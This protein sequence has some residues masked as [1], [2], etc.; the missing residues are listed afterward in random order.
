MENPFKKKS[1]EITEHFFR[2]EYGRILPVITKYLGTENIITAEDIVQETLL[3]AVKYWQHHGIPQNPQAWLYTTAKNLTFNT[4]K[5]EKFQH[6]YQK[7]L[8]QD[9]ATI[10]QLIFTDQIITDEQLRMMFNCCHPAITE[11][12]QITLILKVL[13]GFSISEIANAFFTSK[14]TINKRLVRGRKKLREIGFSLQN[15]ENTHH[16]LPIVLKTIYLIFNEGYYPSHKNKVI[17]YDLC[18]EAIRLL[19]IIIN[20]HVIQQKDGA[21]ALLALMYLNASRFEARVS[22]DNEI[23][24]LENQNRV[25][26]DQTLINRGIYCLNHAIAGGHI[27]KYLILANISAQ[28]CIAPDFQSTNWTE[29][30]K[31][32]DY[33]LLL[34]DTPINHLN[35]CVALSK[36][37]GNQTAI[38]EL[39]NIAG[40]STLNDYYLYHTTL[41]ELYTLTNDKAI[42]ISHY[43]QAI[44]LVQNPRDKSFIEKKIARLVPIS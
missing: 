12:S 28:H 39:R 21:Y 2:N 11:D 17:R 27:S 29:I 44:N 41:A 3:K 9:Y 35:R 24:D 33:L 22:D 25:L 7:T 37:E 5:R 18:L 42:A 40:N 19:E 38:A 30:L 1:F 10:D 43:E 20:H 23:V 8:V 14:E 34:E 15:A 4:L 32:Y 26:W 36:V 13:C 16:S 6:Q 31:L